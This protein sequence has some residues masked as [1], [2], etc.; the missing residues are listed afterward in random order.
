M[1]N[2][3]I[4]SASRAASLAS[5]LALG[6]MF[7]G[8]LH[9]AQAETTKQCEGHRKSCRS[10]C[11]VITNNNPSMG[12]TRRGCEDRCESR[13]NNC[14]NFASDKKKIE[15]IVQDK[16]TAVPDRHK[17]Q[18]LKREATPFADPGKSR[19]SVKSDSPVVNPGKIAPK[20]DNAPK[21]QPTNELRDR[22]R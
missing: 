1:L 21:I 5:L 13:A 17:D 19:P 18:V 6:T 12:P 7:P 15:K 16:Q 9:I 3:N 20:I 4:I 22:R 2:S 14:N 8:G 11:T 10:D